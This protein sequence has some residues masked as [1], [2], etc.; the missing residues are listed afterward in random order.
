M[1]KRQVLTF[2]SITAILLASAALSTGTGQSSRLLQDG[3]S[4]YLIE[5]T[6]SGTTVRPAGAVWDGF[7]SESG[8]ATGAAAMQGGTMIQEGDYLYLVETVGRHTF[9]RRVSA[10]WDGNV[11]GLDRAP[12]AATQQAR[13]Q[14]RDQG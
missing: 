13:V 6:R 5:S 1:T 10:V 14:A 2:A 12:G 3:D 7:A 11:A 8:R 4:L 9:K